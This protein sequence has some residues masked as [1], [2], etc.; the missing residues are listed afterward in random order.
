[1]VELGWWVWPFPYGLHSDGRRA[2]SGSR[3]V[4]HGI[5]I[6]EMN[7]RFVSMSMA[8]VNSIIT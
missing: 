6:Q 2:S 5:G 8:G 1:M 7:H 3:S 4:S